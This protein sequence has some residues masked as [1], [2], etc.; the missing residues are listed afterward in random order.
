M[1]PRYRQALVVLFVGVVAIIWGLVGVASSA[2]LALFV[3]SAAFPIAV[4]LAVSGRLGV[5]PPMG[6]LVGGGTI[7][8]LVAVFSHFFVFGFAYF[9]FLGFAQAATSLLEALRVD[10]ALVELA[11]SPWMV[12]LLYEMVM[13]APF[14]EEIGKA[15]GAWV[16]RPVGRTDA[17][18]AG[19]AAGVGFA[20]VENVLYATGGLL[21]G[22]SWEAISATRMVGAAI[23]P[24]ASGLVVMGF[25]EWRHGRNVG[26]LA[27]RFLS[28]VGVHA[29][30][31]GSIVVVGI[32]GQAYGVDQLLGFGTLAVVYSAGLGVLAVAALWRVS[33]S[34]AAGEERLAV[35]EGTD[36]ITIGSWMVVAA[37]LLVP[38][39]LLFLAYPDFVAG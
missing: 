17:F 19:V 16:Q 8:P 37:S 26:L 1:K 2:G 10:P 13:F 15:A 28:G 18:M 20:I 4:L 33:A 34:V 38:V 9:F 27:R 7:G 39:A 25:W 21:F 29:L 24:L 22:P 11:G 3:G 12:L 30:W 35:F 36:A 14:T 31:N 23:H 32:V 6:S 5:D